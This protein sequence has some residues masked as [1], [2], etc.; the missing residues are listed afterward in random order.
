M[1]DKVKLFKEIKLD[2]TKFISAFKF[3]NYWKEVEIDENTGEVLKDSYEIDQYRYSYKGVSIRYS[4]I[5]NKLVFQGKLIDILDGNNENKNLV[6]NLD[7]VYSDRFLIIDKINKKIEELIGIEV[8][9]KDFEVS[10]IEV[11]FNIYN[12]DAPRYIEVFNKVF[13]EK[14]SSRYKNY[15]IENNLSLESSYY[16]KPKRAY[17][18]NINESYTVNFYNKLDQLRNLEKN[19]NYSRKITDYDKKLAENTL[20]LEVQLYYKELKKISK[21]FKDYLDIDFCFNIVKSKYEY[22]ISRNSKLNFYSYKGYKE[23]I[24]Q[25]TILK[26]N[27]KKKLKKYMKGKYANNKKEIS[28]TNTKRLN[29][30]GIHETLIDSDYKVNY[31]ESPIELLRQKIEKIK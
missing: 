2:T 30:I 17:E 21:T 13:K 23:T 12:V 31:L 26:D 16:V 4:N 28:K 6:Y 11:T 18:K 24:E 27:E 29:K 15:V 19:E 14:N 7:D 22:F 20:R 9:I 8:D 1:I 5:S 10:Q 3:E 25:S